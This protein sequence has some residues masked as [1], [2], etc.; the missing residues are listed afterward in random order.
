MRSTPR[1]WSG[2]RNRFR[3]LVRRLSERGAALRIGTNHGSLSDRIM[4]R[5]GD[6][7]LGMV[8]SALEFLDVCEAEGYRDV[9]FSMKASNAQ[10]AIQA[11]RMLAS[12]LEERA[13]GEPGYPF[14][15]G[16]TEAGDGEDGRIKSAIGIGSLLEDG[17]G[18]TIRV[19]LT[20]EPVREI[21]VAAAL[22]RRADQRWA[23]DR[24]VPAS[25]I[26]APFCADPYA[27]AR[28]H[29]HELASRSGGFAASETPDAEELLRIGGR[30]PVRVELELGRLDPGE[31]ALDTDGLAAQLAISLGL[32][33]ELPCEGLRDLGDRCTRSLPSGRS[34][35][36]R[37]QSSVCACRSSS[38]IPLQLAPDAAKASF[39]AVRFA[40]PAEAG[41]SVGQL[42]GALT[43]LG[44]RG[45]H[46][47]AGALRRGRRAARSGGSRARG[48]EACRNP[49]LLLSVASPRATHGARIVASR[50]HERSADCPLLLRFQSPESGR[51]AAS[52]SGS[53]DRPRS[54]PL[55][56]HRRRHLAS[57]A[58]VRGRRLRDRRR[59]SHPSGRSSAKHTDRV[60]LV[61][62]LRPDP[63]RSRGD[64]RA[65]QAE[66]PAT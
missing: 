44:A 6:T 29:S 59:V 15:V 46:A 8:E 36:A 18:D 31:L 52:A 53:R 47:R 2:W 63:V 28:R 4:N 10:V 21:P 61:S 42:A 39:P 62:V 16:V 20:E 37:W 65:H 50:L 3:P 38:K 24:A 64:D 45:L 5:Y 58:G 13:P 34:W 25:R 60:H 49:R 51:P 48:V 9:V 27:H 66:E 19:S 33:P 41:G 40:L 43:Q 12:R 35:R 26:A 55:R 22:A 1:S 14:H 23:E 11:Y 54:P 30:A 7:P 32:L 56:R 57:G 17:I